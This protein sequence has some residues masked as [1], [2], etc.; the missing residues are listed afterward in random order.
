MRVSQAKHGDSLRSTSLAA[1]TMD[2]RPRIVRPLPPSSWGNL[3]NMVTAIFVA[4]DSGGNAE[5]LEL[6]DFVG[7][8]IDSITKSKETVVSREYVFLRC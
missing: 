2:L 8:L 6:K 3:V 7:L 4:A 5:V 1:L